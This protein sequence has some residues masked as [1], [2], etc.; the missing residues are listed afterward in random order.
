[1]LR[2][3]LE[4]IVKDFI[5]EES[6]E[7]VHN[8][9]RYLGLA[10]AGVR[11][12]HMDISGSPTWDI[13]DVDVNTQTISIPEDCMAISKLGYIALRSNAVIPL[14]LDDDMNL[15]AEESE[16]V[17]V[18]VDD[19]K[20]SYGFPSITGVT[21]RKDLLN[22][23]IKISSNIPTSYVYIEY[24][25]DRE[26]ING[27]YMV[28]PY[29]IEAVKSFIRWAN[30]RSNSNVPENKVM[31]YERYW[32]RDRELALMRSNP[33]TLEEMVQEYRSTNTGAPRQ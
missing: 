28:F 20:K 17:T 12:L 2:F 3:K 29:E 30:V 8:F 25:K 11:E 32:T 27:K 33:M 9:R 31:R 7:T 15:N 21:Y 26:K 5:D 6:D 23:V 22:G 14:I 24:L 4:N 18:S 1:M 10:I 16:G 19:F 13:L